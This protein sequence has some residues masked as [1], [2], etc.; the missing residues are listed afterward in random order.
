[1]KTLINATLILLPV[2]LNAQDILY[3][4]DNSKLEVKVYEITNTT[5][6]YKLNSDP[7]GSYYIIN[8]KDAAMVIYQ[9]GTHEIFKVAETFSGYNLKDT[10]REFKRKQKFKE[11]T[12]NDNVIFVNA[13]ELLN[14]GIGISYLREVYDNRFSVHVPFAASY[15]Q[16]ELDNALNAFGSGNGKIQKTHYD[17]GLGLYLNTSGKRRVTHFVGPLI[18]NAQYSGTFQYGISDANYNHRMAEGTFSMNETSLMLNNGFLYRITPAF[19]IL[20]NFAFGKFIDRNYKR[21]EMQKGAQIYAQPS[22]ELA[23]HAGFHLGYRF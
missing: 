8:K 21:G 6:K 2:L 23:L 12:Q 14:S 11:V 4:T 13:V 10:L 5:I 15:G 18:R 1:M 22:R 3:K 19:N 16:P 9:N 17:I 20:I 7:G